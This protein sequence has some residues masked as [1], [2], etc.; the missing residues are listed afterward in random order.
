MNIRII[1]L[2]IL[3]IFQVYSGYATYTKLSD[4]Q[5]GGRVVSVFICGNY[6]YT[7]RYDGLFEIIN[8]SDPEQPQLAGSIQIPEYIPGVDGKVIVSD[9]LAYILG[10]NYIHVVNIANPSEPAYIAVWNYSMSS[11]I[12]ISGQLAYIA[13]YYGFR[14]LDISNVQNPLLLG[15][16]YNRLDGICLND[17][18]IYGVHSSS[19]NNLH[20]YDVSDPQAPVILSMDLDLPVY[21]H[22]DIAYSDSH[23]FVVYS[24]YFW[25]IDV[26]DPANPVIIDTLRVTGG[27]NK[28]WINNDQAIINNKES[29]LS[30]IDI[31]DPTEPALSGYYDTSGL[32]EQAVAE[33]DIAYSADCY[34]G[35]QIIDITEGINP[36]QVG[37]LSTYSWA[38]G[39]DSKDNYLYLADA[40][41]LDVIDISDVTE[42]LL[43]GYYFNSYGLSDEVSVHNNHL[44]FSH[45]L[46]WPQL[47]FI[48][49]SNPGAP[50]L[51]DSINLYG[52]WY[53]YYGWVPIDQNDSYVFIGTED[54]LRIYDI[55]DFSNPFQISGYHT[56]SW[57][58]DVLA[59]NYRAYISKW[60]DGIDIID[61]ENINMPLFV[62]SYHTSGSAGELAFHSGTLI[63]ADG[64]G[65]I[66]LVDVSNPA[67]PTLIS[68]I[69][70]HLNSD[71][72]AN[73]IIINNKMIF[74]DKE[75]NEIF[76]YDISDLNNILLLN[77]LKINAE[78]YR[79]IYHADVF[80]C[81]ALSHGL[82][83]LNP[84]P[85]LR[86]DDGNINPGT[87][88]GIN[89]F[90][91]P[92]NSAT[93]IK[94]ELSNN[95]FVNIEICNQTGIKIRTLVNGFE[96]AGIHYLTWDGTD[97]N[98]SK[99]STGFYFLKFSS[100]NRNDVKQVLVMR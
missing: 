62:G 42:P 35:L 31:S 65:G 73:P 54:S 10:Y 91:N 1:N 19:P 80:F 86:G 41:G 9:S 44:C 66:Q 20:I 18:I 3:L 68:T 27:T 15:S 30:V 4:Y 16:V 85:I 81:S 45:N 34:S 60:E 38:I 28:I 57:I 55:S 29:G 53:D 43:T 89:I 26:Y 17:S 39:L 82:I 59:E 5:S 92:S 71:I 90:P 83:V 67:C 37:S 50:V 75:W 51:M 70:P 94:Y 74:V 12:I 100:G 2:N 23:V 63:I 98:H 58:M 49:I 33:N 52:G 87:S 97:N 24:G 69:K 40:N 99:V 93:T 96:K 78:I 21:S 25:T 76:T 7:A 36:W 47:N 13:T 95:S 22:A 84:S 46:E 11:D 6:A 56:S 72:V 61:L 32:C 8:V 77:S 79:I 48:D 14:I 88:D 64:T